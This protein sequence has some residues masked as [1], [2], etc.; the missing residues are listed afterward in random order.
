LKIGEAMQLD[1]M[2]KVFGLNLYITGMKLPSGE[3]LIVAS[4]VSNICDQVLND[5]KKGGVLNVYSKR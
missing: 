4:Y 5:Y 1:G 3:L 2:R